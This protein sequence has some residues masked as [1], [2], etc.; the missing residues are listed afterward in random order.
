MPAAFC[1]LEFDSRPSRLVPRSYG[2]AVLSTPEVRHH[3]RRK[4][5]DGVVLDPPGIL[6]GDAVSSYER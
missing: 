5:L 6:A 4:R 1:F 2:V 3:L